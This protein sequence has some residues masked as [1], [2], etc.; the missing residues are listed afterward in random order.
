MS[1]YTIFDAKGEPT[2]ILTVHGGNLDDNIPD[3]GGAYPG[4]LDLEREYVD[5]QIHERRERPPMPVSVDGHTIEV[6]AGVHFRIR[7]PVNLSGVAEDGRMDLNI[8]EPGEY[9]VTLK[10]FP[11]LDAEVVIH[12]G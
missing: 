2:G 10:L 11:Y 9:T 7:G 1:T 6:S 5:P 3:G 12:A 8:S 4:R